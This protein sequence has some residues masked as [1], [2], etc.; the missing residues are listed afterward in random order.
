MDIEEKIR[1][2]QLELNL[3][4][5]PEEKQ[6]IR[7]KLEILQQLKRIEQIKEKLKNL[8]EKS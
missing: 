4:D 1:V 6:R 5:S 3:A 8:R 7:N 2:A